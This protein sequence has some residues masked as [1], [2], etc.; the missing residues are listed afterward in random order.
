MDTAKNVK[1]CVIAEAVIAV[2]AG[3]CGIL[4]GRGV[5]I[6]WVFGMTFGIVGAIIIP[7]AY[8]YNLNERRQNNEY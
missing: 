2:I 4:T 5:V 8:F 7:L 6:P 3:I 1:S